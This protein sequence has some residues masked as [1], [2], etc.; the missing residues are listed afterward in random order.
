MSIKKCILSICLV[1][2]ML[3]CMLLPASAYVNDED[4]YI[5]VGFNGACAVGVIAGTTAGELERSLEGAGLAYVSI[6]QSDGTTALSNDTVY[7]GMTARVNKTYYI[8]IAVYGDVDGDGTVNVSDV[9]AMSSLYGE[10]NNNEFACAADMDFNGTVSI[11]DK[12][13]LRDYI[14]TGAGTAA[15]ISTKYDVDYSQPPFWR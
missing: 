8:K 14:S 7:T 9:T 13:Y 6:R 10:V 15:F 5:R 1:C 11:S 3:S 12:Y 2:S 4:A